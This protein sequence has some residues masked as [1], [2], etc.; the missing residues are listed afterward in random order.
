MAIKH[1]YWF[2]EL[3]KGSLAIAG[4]KGANLGEMANAGF[5]VPEGYCVSVESYRQ[6]ILLNNLDAFIKK[7]TENL[8]VE[9]SAALQKASDDIKSAMMGAEMPKEISDAIGAAYEKLSAQASGVDQIL[10]TISGFEGGAYVA[11][12]SSATAED[13]PEASFAGQQSTYLNVRGTAGVVDA[14]KRCWASLFEAR[15]IYYRIQNGF[16]HLSVGLCAV[17]QRMVN[18]D[19]SGVMFTVDPISQDHGRIVIEGG[20]GLG[21]A[22]V[23]G[24][25]TPDHFE[26]DKNSLQIISKQVNAQEKMIVRRRDGQGNDELDVPQELVEAQKVSDG[27]VMEIASIGRSIERHYG[28]PQDIE[29][30]IEGGRTYIVQSRPITTLDRKTDDAAPENADGQPNPDS[31]QSPSADAMA[32]MANPQSGLSSTYSTGSSFSPSDSSLPSSNL[33]STPTIHVVSPSGEST[34]V[35]AGGDV[36]LLHG[37][38]AAPGIASGPVRI[39]LDIKEIYRVKNGDV[40]VTHMTTPDFV[41]AMKRAKAIITDEGGMTCHAAIVSRELGVPCVVGTRNGTSA[42]H[43]DEIVTVDAKRGIIYEG[44]LEMAEAKTPAQQV[45][46]HVTRASPIITGTKIYVNI[47]E[48]ELADRTA[49]LAVDGVGLLRAEFMIAGIGV[50]PK[51]LI[52]EGR[53]QEFVDSLAKGLRKV[54][55]AFYPRPIIYRATDFKT[56]E[57]RNLEGGEEF[58]PH[59]ENPM[60]GYRG[61]F[62]YIKDPEEFALELEAIKKVREQYGMKNLHLMIPVVRTVHEFT[63]V[64]KLVE[65]S[66]LHKSRDFKLGMMCEVPSNVILAEEFCKAGADFFSIGSNDLTQLTLG[67]DRDNPIVAEEFDE[68]D[69]AIYQSLKHVIV[70]CH[71]YGVKVG[72]CGQAPSV[73]PEFAEKLVDYGIDSISVNPD[74]VDLTRKV[75]AS[76]EMRALLERGRKDE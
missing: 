34:A 45:A 72:I 46:E 13:V 41:P 19:A 48:P 10:P 12:R 67:I 47:A 37:L 6:F 9:D 57:Y 76:A 51:K 60:I 63:Q 1:I 56:N 20:L 22:I 61:C 54:C 68:R 43:E 59:E 21:E 7:K 71:K 33:P 50:H 24:M 31:T 8:D 70:T 18:S 28:S 58:E 5:P 52:K 25:I 11:V 26:V 4:G 44:K 17:V 73:Y 65:A 40:L 32:M 38:G 15:A 49:D 74:V 35:K 42:L 27:A 36:A 69:D 66:G 53:Q 55:A 64:K 14:V 23:S 30:A 3:G 2:G 16:D 75:V 39:I 62:R 29:W